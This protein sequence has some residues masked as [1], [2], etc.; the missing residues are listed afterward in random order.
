MDHAERTSPSSIS[1]KPSV[2]GRDR[3]GF[4][5]WPAKNVVEL[6]LGGSRTGAQPSA[7]T[8]RR[9]RVC[10][11]PYALQTGSTRMWRQSQVWNKK[12]ATW[13]DNAHDAEVGGVGC[14]EKN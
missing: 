3:P 9:A 1:A 4:A 13:E 11:S 12:N 14:E 2:W 7:G 8:S 10:T 6:A 5:Q